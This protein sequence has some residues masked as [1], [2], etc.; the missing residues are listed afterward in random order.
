MAVHRELGL[1]L[2]EAAYQKALAIEFESKR[3]VFDQEVKFPIVYKGN[4]IPEN[5]IE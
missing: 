2:M 4:R 5:I 1:G 3:I